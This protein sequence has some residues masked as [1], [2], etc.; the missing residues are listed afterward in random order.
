MQKLVWKMDIGKTD[1]VDYEDWGTDYCGCWSRRT[2]E[3]MRK[4][5]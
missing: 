2:H 1:Y 3:R 4:M 5:V